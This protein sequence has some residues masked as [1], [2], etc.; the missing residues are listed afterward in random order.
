MVLSKTVLRPM[1]WRIPSTDKR[2]THSK[3][4]TYMHP[5]WGVF[6]VVMLHATSHRD[7]T[8]CIPT[9]PVMTATLHK[10]SKK[11]SRINSSAILLWLTEPQGSLHTNLL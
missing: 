8:R 6:A 2:H 11:R 4:Y 10:K 5:T 9:T 3:S 7:E 1:C